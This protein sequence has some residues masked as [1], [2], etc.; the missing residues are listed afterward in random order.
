MESI[1]F[2]IVWIWAI[3]TIGVSFYNIARVYFALYPVF[4][5]YT[6][7]EQFEWYNGLNKNKAII[8]ITYSLISLFIALT[9]GVSVI[10]YDSWF[11]VLMNL[12]INILLQIGLLLIIEIKMPYS[13]VQ[14]FKNL[15]NKNFV[16]YPKTNNNEQKKNEVDASMQILQNINY[17]TISTQEKVEVLIENFIIETPFKPKNTYEKDIPGTLEKYKIDKR[18]KNDVELLLKGKVPKEPIIFTLL[19]SGAINKK[20]IFSFYNDHFE[21]MDTKTKDWKTDLD[22]IVDFVN[23]Y[24]RFETRNKNY[25]DLNEGVFRITK[26]ILSRYRDKI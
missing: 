5:H 26:D 1:A 13:I 6:F 24:S 10:K 14:T 2:L 25:K 22:L 7:E 8:I 23:K 17:T 19:H 9:Y 3:F 15:L 18:S 4:I 21:F 16:Y 20:I 12:F 11:D